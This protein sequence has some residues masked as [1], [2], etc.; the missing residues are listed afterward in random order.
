MGIAVLSGLVL[1]AGACGKSGPDEAELK[2]A[3]D[4]HLANNPKCIVD[5]A[6]QFPAEFRSEYDR[7]REPIYVA[8]MARV[9]ALVRLGLLRAA[10]GPSSEWGRPVRYELTDEGRRAY[11][12]LPGSLWDTRKRLG[13]FC[14]GTPEVESIIRHTEPAE[15]L[16]QVQTEV[17]YR[18]R[19]REV[20]PWA[21][22]SILRS[23]APEIT[24]ETDATGVRE[25]RLILVQTSDGW[26]VATAR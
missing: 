1:L 23:V 15:G 21:Q 9:D 16:G 20:A 11:R 24:Q 18:Y 13:A 10:S 26:K 7:A 8:M 19:L 6:W 3:I 22:D 17:T 2:R 4:E 25:A 5:P 12:D 14:Y